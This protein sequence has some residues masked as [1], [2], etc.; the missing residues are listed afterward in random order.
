MISNLN[1]QTKVIGSNRGCCYSAIVI[2]Y[3]GSVSIPIPS[4]YFC[5]RS[6]I[7]SVDT[8]PNLSTLNTFIQTPRQHMNTVCTFRIE[9]VSTGTKYEEIKNIAFLRKIL[10]FWSN[11]LLVFSNI[12]KALAN[13]TPIFHFYTPENDRRSLV[14]QDFFESYKLCL[15]ISCRE[16]SFIINKRNQK[17]TSIMEN[18]RKQQGLHKN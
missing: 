13:F 18:Q 10:K 7:N 4:I 11:N 12:S 14:F 1:S 16:Y 5:K 6:T 17:L 9:C 2:T 15:K 3:D 8:Q